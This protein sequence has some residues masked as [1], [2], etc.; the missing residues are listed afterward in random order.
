[1]KRGLFLML[2]IGLCWTMALAQDVTE[3]KVSLSLRQTTLEQALYLLMDQYGIPLSF[4]NSLLP[5]K[6]V[7]A[8]I[9]AR[10][11]EDVL[12][13][14]FDQT[15]ISYR[16]VGR[17]IVLYEH[18]YEVP[19]LTEY[20]TVRGYVRDADTG[21][22]LLS[23]S[24]HDLSSGQGT[25][26]NAYGFFSLRLPR[27]EALLTCSYLGYNPRS[28]EIDLHAD[29]VLNLGLTT[30]LMLDEVLVTAQDFPPG[31]AHSGYSVHSLRVDDVLH[32]PAFGGEPDVIR[33]A[34]LL[35]GVQTGADG[36]GGM[37]VRG[38]DVGQ[39]L[40]L[41]DGVPVY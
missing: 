8:E 11:L 13:Y 2:G 18:T 41:L 36:F 19:D 25:L 4:S 39:N 32:L 17:Q 15:Q 16:Q 28:T 38:G 1:M 23:A 37:Y 33:T 35:P 7:T 24:V 3:Q 27:G 34:Q 6:T 10:R 30:S 9:K 29:R 14:L 5:D 26:T 12:D 21:E 31:Y 40:V 20:V 22:P